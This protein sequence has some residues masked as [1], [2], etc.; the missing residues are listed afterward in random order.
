[1]EATAD[2]PVPISRKELM[3]FIGMTGYYRKFCHN[4][5]D[6]TVTLTTCNYSTIEK[7]TF[8]LILALNHFDV[9]LGTTFH[10]IQVFTD[11]NPLT[12]INRMKNNNLR[13]V[14]WWL[15]LQ[16]FNLDIKHIRGKDNII[17]D[18]AYLE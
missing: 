13:L 17:A 18:L 3:R 5:S 14:R 9:Y 2:F 4:F 1:M 15:S 12:F 16:E 7:E 11:H 10:P 8:A 6:V